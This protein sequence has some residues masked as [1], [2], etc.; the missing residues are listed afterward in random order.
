VTCTLVNIKKIV[1]FESVLTILIFTYLL[2]PSSISRHYFL[3]HVP[4]LPRLWRLKPIILWFTKLQKWPK[5][6]IF[7][8]YI[9]TKWFF[10]V[11]I[12]E[13]KKIAFLAPGRCQGR[14][15][16]GQPRVRPSPDHPTRGCWSTC[17]GHLSLRKKGRSPPLSSASHGARSFGEFRQTGL[18]GKSGEGLL[19]FS[20]VLP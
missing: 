15:H 9:I 20:L 13:K 10:N 17:Q 14:R 8:I 5:S 2:Y 12:S 3:T 7:C 16:E 11:R 6:P 19:I 18:V 1:S 4:A